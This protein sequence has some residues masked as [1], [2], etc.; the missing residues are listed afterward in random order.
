MENVK[1][2]ATLDFAHGKKSYTLLALHAF[3]IGIAPALFDYSTNTVLYPP[4]WENIDVQ[5]I[6][7]SMIG[8][9]IR[10]AIS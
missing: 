5:A 9:T 10:K 3:F 1:K 7:N 6:W 4:M 8:A 2:V